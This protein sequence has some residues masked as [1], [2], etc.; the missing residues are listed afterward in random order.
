[1]YCG[2]SSIVAISRLNWALEPRYVNRNV[3]KEKKKHEQK[4]H[5]FFLIKPVKQSFSFIVLLF[6][7]VNR[8]K[9]GDISYATV[10]LMLN[11]MSVF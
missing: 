8:G 2:M 10:S 4:L 7:E 3:V 9:G 6:P 1:M 11:S 5:L